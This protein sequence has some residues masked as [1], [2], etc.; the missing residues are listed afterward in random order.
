MVAIYV[1]SSVVMDLRQANSREQPKL[2]FTAAFASKTGLVL[3]ST[4]F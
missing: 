1:F 2:L 3:F 4:M